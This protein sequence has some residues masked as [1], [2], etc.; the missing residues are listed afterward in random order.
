LHT[1]WNFEFAFLRSRRFIERL[2]GKEEEEK[3]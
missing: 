1:V 3:W 2:K